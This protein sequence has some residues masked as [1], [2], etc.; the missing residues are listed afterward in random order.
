MLLST[1]VSRKP[2]LCLALVVASA[3][4][5]QGCKSAP[6]PDAG[7]DAGP[8]PDAG[9]VTP[10]AAAGVPLADGTPCGV[11]HIC[12]SGVCRPGATW[13]GGGDC[14]TGAVCTLPS[15]EGST[16]CLGQCTD[17]SSDPKNCGTC[18]LVCWTGSTC[19]QG[20]CVLGSCVGAPTRALCALDGGALGYCCD[21]AC[22]DSVSG[23]DCGECGMRCPSDAQ[24]S[25]GGCVLPDS[26]FPGAPFDCSD[27]GCSANEVCWPEGNPWAFCV[28][29][30][31]AGSVSGTVC[32]RAATDP[33][34]GICCEAGCV[35]PATD[36]ANCGHC[37]LVCP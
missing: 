37:G 9:P 15:G 28:V 34:T 11:G 30:S 14:P 20:Q 19:Q 23:P 3:W 5:A 17:H 33:S 2:R 4:L 21:G 16:C 6:I 35:D 31:C 22:F 13:T 27:A 7:P 26:G 25:V 24:C 36:A 10:C 12:C 32:V 8:P 18:G 1:A 29:E